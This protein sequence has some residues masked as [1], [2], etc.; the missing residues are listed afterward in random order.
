MR[1]LRNPLLGGVGFVV[2]L[3]WAVFN[4]F[5]PEDDPLSK[6]QLGWSLIV[7]LV[8]VLQ[9]ATALIARVRR[10]EKQIEP[11]LHL[12]FRPDLGDPFMVEKRP[13]NDRVKR[14][15]R[16]GVVNPTAVSVEDVAVLVKSWQ[17]Q[18]KDV[19][20]FHELERMGQE[21]GQTGSRFRVTGHSPEPRVFVEVLKQTIN[22][23]TGNGFM[24]EIMLAR[25]EF[26]TQLWG[27]QLSYKFSLQID[28]EGAGPFM[29]FIYER[30]AHG[31][32]TLRCNEFAKQ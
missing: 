16:V 14:I 10:L 8:F 11:R 5:G 7:A 32:Y 3:C 24:P 9:G 31:I 28:G 12:V 15:Y 27:R 26:S 17:P 1:L 6:T 21:E 20:L 25:G 2:A 22:K 4:F 18:E 29:G 23:T 19:R 30:D 13:D